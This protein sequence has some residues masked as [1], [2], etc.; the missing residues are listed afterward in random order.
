L[1]KGESRVHA[2]MIQYNCKIT[3]V[4]KE[5]CSYQCK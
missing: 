3:T 1:I 5:I 2:S 4:I